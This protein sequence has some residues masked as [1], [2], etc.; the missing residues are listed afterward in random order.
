MIFNNVALQVLYANGS[1]DVV[2]HLNE[3]ISYTLTNFF[4]IIAVVTLVFFI[5]KSLFKSK[6]VEALNKK[7]RSFT[8]LL[9]FALGAAFSTYSYVYSIEPD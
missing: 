1:D 6:Y 5:I 7:Y 8:P 3:Y 9:S 2:S 4:A